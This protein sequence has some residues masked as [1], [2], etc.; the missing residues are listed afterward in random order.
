MAEISG[1]N[2]VVYFNEGLTV[3]AATGDIVFSTAANTITS[4]LIDFGAT[5]IGFKAGMLFDLSECGNTGNDRIYTIDT[6]VNKVITPIEAISSGGTDTG[7][8][9]FLEEEPGIEVLGFYNWSLSYSGGALETTN[10]DNSSGGRAYIP[11][12]TSWTATAEKHFLTT[13]N[14]VD[15]WVGQTC[16]IRLF[17]KYVAIS[18]ASDTSQYWKGDTIVTGLDHTTPVDALVN[19]SIS[20]QGDRALTLMTQ[21]QAWNLGITT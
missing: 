10:F 5:G 2:G 1:E 20:F 4:T 19:Q 13:G 16:E 8:P 6:V 17:T 18:T 7:K 11:G 9:V 21:T 14:E 3:T 12:L 15:D